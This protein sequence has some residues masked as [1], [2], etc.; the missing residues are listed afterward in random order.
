MNKSKIILI[1]V[2]AVIIVAVLAMAFFVWSSFAAKVAAAEGDD[3]G[4]DGLETVVSMAQTLSR[5]SIFPSAQS[6]KAIESNVTVLAEWKD[7][8]HK[9]V[10]AGDRV[11]EKPPP[12]P[13][14]LLLSMTLSG[15]GLC[16][17]RLMACSSRAISPL[18]RLRG[19]LP[20]P[21]CRSIQSLHCF[22]VVGT[23]WLP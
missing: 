7:A 6:V 16:R 15:L 17:V 13:S 21:R 22:S 8:A 9:L 19:T 23:T 1:S 2:G 18:G 3:E 12:P 10:S 20:K 4:N 11:F 14:R 5:K